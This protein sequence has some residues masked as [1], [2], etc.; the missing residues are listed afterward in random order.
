MPPHP[1]EPELLVLN[2]LRLKG[3][4]DADVV[5]A[6]C[7]L[8]EP[9]VADVLD[10]LAVDGYVARR[11]G[12]V[13][14]WSLTPAGRVEGERRLASE[15]DRLGCRDVV[16]RAYEQFLT[17]NT[18][19]LECCTR[20]QL[21][22]IDGTLDTNGHDDGDYDASVLADLDRLDDEVQDVC[23]QLASVLARFSYYN[24]RFAVARLRV[25]DGDHDW[26]TKPF[27]DSY[28][29]VWFELHEHL[30]ATLNR[31]RRSEAAF[32]A[33]A[34]DRDQPAHEERRA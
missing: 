11:D 34:V 13:C 30:L 10:R 28:H 2:T 9:V 1:S 33:P 5:A 3:F 7:T 16:E 25:H 15:L 32:G 22:D 14:G 24:G 21:R 20:W 12:R 29:A 27:V 18:P 19:F 6:A 8:A 23:S 4:V 17:L 26:F 31:E